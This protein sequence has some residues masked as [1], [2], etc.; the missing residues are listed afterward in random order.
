MLRLIVSNQELWLLLAVYKRLFGLA[1]GWI[2]DVK[3]NVISVWI[4]IKEEDI[5]VWPDK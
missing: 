1:G 4:L 3:D 5:L 2:E